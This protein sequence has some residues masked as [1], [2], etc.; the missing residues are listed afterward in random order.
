MRKIYKFF[1]A[2]S[3]CLCCSAY[4]ATSAF[5]QVQ[6]ARYISTGP[7][8]NGFYEY[9]PAGYSS[10]TKYPLLVFLHGSGELGN[11]TTDLPNL[12]DDGSPPDLISQ[13]KF[14]TSFTVNGQTF[15][16][17]V[18]SPQFVIWP[19]DADV[20]D[21]INYAIANY[22]VD[23][24]RVY[25]TGL[26]MGGS[27]VWSYAPEDGHAQ[28]LAGIVPIA[29]GQMYEGSYGAQILQQNNVAVF[30]AA[31]LNDPTV[32]SGL[33]VA[34]IQLINSVTP[35]INPPALDTIY[36]ASGHG[37]W[38]ITYD[39]TTNLHNGLNLY[40]YL[41]QFSKNSTTTPLP[42]KLAGFTATLSSAPSVQT[43]LNWTTTFE[44]NNH[45]FLVQRSPDG[46]NFSIIDTVPAAADAENGH[47]YTYTDQH[48]L[49]GPD[50]YRLA[51]V[52]L[53]GTT[54][55][56]PIREVFAGQSSA[57][58]QLSPNP[59]DATVYLELNGS[60]AGSLEVRL[61]DVQGRTMRNWIFQKT[62]GAW[63]QPLDVSG[64][65]AGS[66]FIQVTGANYQAI[67]TFIKK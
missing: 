56:S 30:A 31:N 61:L 60:L 57:A 29:G 11:G 40:Q 58:F 53:D 51:Q 8:S 25:L 26:S 33:T 54:T 38:T 22:K 42:I 19:K 1:L 14:P 17:I 18:I 64:L 39:P 16:F 47:S 67:K 48:P 35:K 13:G 7:N 20:D 52:D 43:L 23:V 34:D 6:T 36:N 59:A 5:A 28:K 49:T 24:N 9:L 2:A 10:G 12:L 46:E 32:N 3:L 50:Y 37:G 45:Y 4:V 65:A 44:E 62:E 63:N 66:Y 27:A 15:S 21:V 41:L 55:Y